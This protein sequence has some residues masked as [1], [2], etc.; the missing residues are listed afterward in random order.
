MALV[1]FAKAKSWGLTTTVLAVA[2]WWPP[3]RPL[4]IAELDPAGGDLAPRYGLSAEPGLVSLAAA[5]RRNLTEEAVWDHAQ[6]LPGDLRALLGPVS[7]EQA[8][9]A[10]S[11]VAGRLAGVTAAAGA[12]VLA[13]CG[14][15]GPASPVGEVVE[16]ADLTVLVARPSAEEIAHLHSRLSAMRS[17]SRRLGL[18]LVGQHPY[19]PPEV[20]AALDVEVIGV[21]DDDAKAAAIL[22]GRAPI[23]AGLRRSAL[24]R[25]AR[26]VAAAI[27]SRVS[28]APA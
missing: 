24:M 26:E 9:A 2:A 21:V 13:D 6:T 4:L 28:S 20:G 16:R 22:S 10:L 12:D 7:A 27:Q 19:G 23:P 11:A 5:A 18:V 3:E 15:L 17:L 8:H 25:S 1:A 14:R